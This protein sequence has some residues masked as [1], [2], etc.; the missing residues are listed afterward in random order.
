[1]YTKSDKFF[2][3]AAFISFLLSVTFWFLVNHDYGLFIGIWVPSILALW[4]GTK[5]QIIIT[6]MKKNNG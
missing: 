6:Y 2:L 1:M 3:I 4:A 5:A